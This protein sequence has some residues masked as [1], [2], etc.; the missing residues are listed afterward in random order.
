MTVPKRYEGRKGSSGLNFI[1][2]YKLVSLVSIGQCRV[3]GKNF[4]MGIS[5]DLHR[6]IVSEC[7][8]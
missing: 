2:T 8:N 3:R 4:E 5:F 1:Q 6:K 7:Q